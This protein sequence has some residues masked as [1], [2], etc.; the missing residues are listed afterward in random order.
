LAAK[1]GFFFRF[2]LVLEEGSTFGR[3]KRRKG[4]N[5]AKY[6]KRRGKEDLRAADMKSSTAFRKEKEYG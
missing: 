2:I 6:D 4:R 5:K 1:R 3:R